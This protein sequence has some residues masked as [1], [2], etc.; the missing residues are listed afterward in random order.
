MALLG[1]AARYEGTGRTFRYR[2]E[3]GLLQCKVY[4][5]VRASN[6][7]S[8]HGGAAHNYGKSPLRA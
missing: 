3:D 4:F 1:A 7:L 8:A 2:L 6:D 5:R